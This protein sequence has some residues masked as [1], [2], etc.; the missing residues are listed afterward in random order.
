MTSINFVSLKKQ[1]QNNIDKQKE[2]NKAKTNKQ[3]SLLFEYNLRKSM[4]YGLETLH[5]HHITTG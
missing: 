2:E 4:K 3:T 1:K 5:S